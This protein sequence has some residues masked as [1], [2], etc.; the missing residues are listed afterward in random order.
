M[1]EQAICGEESAGSWGE[2]STGGVSPRPC[3]AAQL[4][5]MGHCSW[6]IHGSVKDPEEPKTGLFSKDLF[7]VFLK[8]LGD[9]SPTLTRA[10]SDVKTRLPSLTVKVTPRA[11]STTLV[12]RW[13]P[14]HFWVI[15]LGESSAKHLHF[16]QPCSYPWSS[17]LA[18]RL[19]LFLLSG[20]VCGCRR[21]S[22]VFLRQWLQ[23]TLFHSTHLANVRHNF[24]WT[25]AH[26]C[27]LFLSLVAVGNWDGVNILPESDTLVDD[28]KLKFLGP[29]Q[30]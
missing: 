11:N 5:P 19:L 8:C 6:E 1:R 15:R 27:K 22:K 9:K 21:D 7:L 16:C 29:F 20:G 25:W 12:H 28:T 3:R 30:F 10:G 18:N 4:H 17:C 26:K 24:C 14:L 23:S 2:L 13:A